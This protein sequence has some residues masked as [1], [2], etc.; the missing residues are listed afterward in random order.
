METKT[1]KCEHRFDE[2]REYCE[3]CG[4]S[5]ENVLI[6]ERM[7]SQEMFTTLIEGGK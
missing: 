5:V 3:K 6:E 1:K 7:I 4:R 2:K